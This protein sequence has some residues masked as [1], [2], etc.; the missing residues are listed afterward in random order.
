MGWIPYVAMAV[1]Q[2]INYMKQRGAD[3]RAS[4]EHRADIHAYQNDPKVLMKNALVNELFAKHPEWAEK[5][6][7]VQFALLHPSAPKGPKPTADLL[8]N[9]GGFL[10]DAASYY[11]TKKND[12]G[13]AGVPRA[14][15][16][17]PETQC[18]GG[19]VYIEGYGCL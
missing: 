6:P 10:K 5:Y 4:R 3:K 13:A 2:G 17:Q 16:T 18:P 12:P 8:G 1:G 7:G 19:S 9:A 11:V 15:A 14:S